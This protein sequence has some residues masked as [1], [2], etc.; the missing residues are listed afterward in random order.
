MVAGQA[1]WERIRLVVTVKSYPQPSKKYGESVCVAGVRTDVPEPRWVRLYPVTFRDL[2]AELQF[3][4]WTEME[5]LVSK[6]SDSRPESLKADTSSIVIVRRLGAE[7]NWRDRMA[8]VEPLV[9]PSMCEIQ[10]QHEAVGI[11]LGAFRPARVVDVTVEPEPAEWDEEDKNALAQ[12]NLFAPGKRPLE[13]IPW[14]WRYRY[15]CGPPCGGHHQSVIDWE[16]GEA[17]RTWRRDYGPAQAAE[18]VRRKWLNVLCGPER[19][20]VFLVGNQ[21]KYPKNFLVLGV[22]WPRR[23][24]DGRHFQTRFDLSGHI[25]DDLPVAGGGEALDA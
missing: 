5:L 15:S 4:K 9:T 10:R 3:P 1:R 13:K 25:G 21:R 12:L 22:C 11:S 18:E 7:H 24:P 23:L 20:P 8:L 17:W 16:I 2:P 6:S 19:D 14:R